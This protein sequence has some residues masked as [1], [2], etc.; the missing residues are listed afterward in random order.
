MHFSSHILF[1]QEFFLRN[2]SSRTDPD[3]NRPRPEMAQAQHD[4]NQKW[5]QL[6]KTQVQDGSN[7]KTAQTD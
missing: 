7:P 3:P 6:E 1:S 2:F 4:P 5:P